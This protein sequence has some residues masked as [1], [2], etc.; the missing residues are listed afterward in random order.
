MHAL[1][2][3]TGRTFGR[4]TVI[5]RGPRVSRS[6][7][8]WVCFCSCGTTR[9]RPIQGQRLR[10]GDTTSC[11]CVRRENGRK[12]A[13]APAMRAQAAKVGQY[14]WPQVCKGCGTRFKGTARQNYCRPSCRPRYPRFRAHA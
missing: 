7:A 13:A 5:E 2:D 14:I 6:Q 9:T 11:G 12:K 8:T 3:L 10:S 4:L 1:M